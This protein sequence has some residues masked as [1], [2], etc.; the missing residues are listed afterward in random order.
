MLSI[1]IILICQT[2]SASSLSSYSSDYNGDLKGSYSVKMGGVKYKIPIELSRDN[3]DYMPKISLRFDS[4]KT[5]SGVSNIAPGWDI[6]GLDRIHMCNKGSGLCYNGLVLEKYGD[7]KEIGGKYIVSQN[8]N[9]TILTINKN[10]LEKENI[11]TKYLSK[12]PYFYDK[13]E[14]AYKMIDKITGEVKY[15]SA[16]YFNK[17]KYS[18]YII[19]KSNA[20]GKVVS[21]N[22]TQDSYIR[23]ISDYNYVSDIESIYYGD[24]K[25]KFEYDSSSGLNNNLRLKSIYLNKNSALYEYFNFNSVSLRGRKD[26]PVSYIDNCNFKSECK[27]RLNFN[28]VKISR[29]PRGSQYISMEVFNNNGYHLNFSF[30]KLTSDFYNKTMPY[31][32]GG[33]F[34]EDYNWNVLK[35]ISNKYNGKEYKK[36]FKYQ[37]M[38]GYFDN[39]MKNYFFVRESSDD[40]LLKLITDFE[41]KELL[42]GKNYRVRTYDSENDELIS[43][44]TT[45]WDNIGSARKPVIRS[46][47][48][49]L[50]TS[51]GIKKI[52]N[53]Y[54]DFKLISKETTHKRLGEDNWEFFEKEDFEYYNDGKVRKN[55][56]TLLK[57]KDIFK[58]NYDFHYDKESHSL[59][60]KVK[61]N[62]VGDSITESYLYDKHGKIIN[63]ITTVNG[64]NQQS[65]NTI[66]FTYHNGYVSSKT[67][68]LGHITRYQTNEICGTPEKIININGLETNFSYDSFCRVVQVKYPSGIVDN[69]KYDYNGSGAT[70]TGMYSS[71]RTISRNDG[72]LIVELFDVNNNII[73]TVKYGFKGVKIYSDKVY[74]NFNRLIMESYPYYEDSEPNWKEYTYDGSGRVI[75]I[76]NL[77]NIK[78]IVYNENKIIETNYKNEVKISYLDSKSNIYKIEDTKSEIYHTYTS[79]GKISKSISNGVVY[80]YAYDEWGNVKRTSD[81]SRGTVSYINDPF[82]KEVSKILNDK[83]KIETRYD[84]LGRITSKSYFKNDSLVREDLWNW[85]KGWLGEISSIS[86]DNYSKSYKYNSY[87]SLEAID[88]DFIDKNINVKYNYDSLGRVIS[89]QGEN[90]KDI[91]RY[92]EYGY[93]ESTEDSKGNKYFV[94]DD[95]TPFN[96]IKKVS[97]GSN[98]TNTI[99]RKKNNIVGIQS[100]HA[101]SLKQWEF[102]K[103]NDN[104]ELYGKINH[105]TT[106]SESYTY[107]PIHRIKDAFNSM[108][109]NNNYN[110]EYDYYGNPKNIDLNLNVE[111][112]GRTVN[113]DSTGPYTIYSFDDNYY[114]N[115]NGMLVSGDGFN[116]VWDMIGKPKEINTSTNNIIY[117]Y[118]GDGEKIAKVENGVETLYIG[119]DY[120]KEFKGVG[121]FSEIVLIS[122][123]DRLNIA[124]EYNGNESDSCYSIL[125]DRLGSVTGIIDGDGNLLETYTYSI[126]GL[127]TRLS[128]EGKILNRFDLGFTGHEDL[129]GGKIVDMQGRFYY[130]KVMRFLS[131]DLFVNKPSNSQS[132]NIY[133]Y[134][135]NNPVTYTDPSGY[136]EHLVIYGWTND[137][138]NYYN[139]DLGVGVNGY[140]SS[141]FGSSGLELGSTHEAYVVWGVDERFAREYVKNN[142]DATFLLNLIGY[143]KGAQFAA[144]IVRSRVFGVIKN[145]DVSARTPVGRAG[146]Q[147]SFPNPNAPKPRNS[148]ET[149]NG[150]T[151]S[152][153]AIDRMQERGYTPSVVESALKNGTP[154]P[155]NRPNTTVFTDTVNK[156]RVVMNSETGNVVT[157]ITGLK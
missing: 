40:G 77:G 70:L 60:S 39:G 35:Y 66:Q 86:G 141:P 96:E 83:S 23:K 129:L 69:Y 73:R 147:N 128:G 10:E 28:F 85:D 124:C 125:T 32:V 15:F 61:S 16:L 133:S 29:N 64:N 143:A 99:V 81:P 19:S 132:Y 117:Q 37:D 126:F 20:Y 43:D 120:K 68:E 94:V 114:Y 106:E 122:S 155:G 134:V 74:D 7:G 8:R 142:Q 109:S 17:Y 97:N 105:L 107:D 93:H 110:I 56:K 44:F 59:K 115:R 135:L 130:P 6:E 150:R 137:I 82:G 144:W 21:Y 71:S 116:I 100:T 84:K 119:K 52:S 50:T 118:S 156:V 88:V 149:I 36:S 89:K 33:T 54:R 127:K 67:N 104:N 11:E 154:S 131:P 111:Y 140:N 103:Y 57:G 113:D 18:Y 98:Y 22:Y 138:E 42:Y 95:L 75:K 5:R 139:I 51:I 152:G 27:T 90:W 80:S 1:L 3:Y 58:I 148:P 92:N 123:Y 62:S 4:N 121:G 13:E 46:V 153:H 91:Y 9:L 26:L 78:S 65:E 63:E 112:G 72:S 41:S 34:S 151:Y 47:E 136:V 145:V 79:H 55:S 24:S 157:V 2:T 87:G 101:G 146:Q 12:N 25:I 53:K 31:K 45:V 102:Y 76:S 30:S 108:I 14:I 49:K 38:R 48:S